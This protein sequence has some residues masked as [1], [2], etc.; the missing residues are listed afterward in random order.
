MKRDEER[1]NRLFAYGMI[2]VIVVS[3]IA[4]GIAAANF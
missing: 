3:A 2:V 4:V 1:L